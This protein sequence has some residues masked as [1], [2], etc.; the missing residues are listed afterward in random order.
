MAFDFYND[1]MAKQAD[2]TI[3]T[4]RWWKHGGTDN[5]ILN[6]TTW[7]AS[8]SKYIGNMGRQKGK[9]QLMVRIRHRQ[10]YLWHTTIV[11][12]LW[13]SLCELEMLNLL[14]QD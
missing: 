9:H 2:I 7:D 8:S 4:D 5:Y 14:Q 12:L 10:Q 13:I 3:N 11:I 1:M 6:N